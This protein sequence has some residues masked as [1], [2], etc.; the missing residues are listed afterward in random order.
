MDLNYEIV[1]QYL[2]LFKNS[3]SPI[4][5]LDTIFKLK[6]FESFNDIGKETF[7]E[8]YFYLN[9]LRDEGLVECISQNPE[10]QLNLG[11]IPMRNYTDW[12]ISISTP[13]RLTIEGFKTLESIS[14]KTVWNNIKDKLKLIGVKSL[15]QIP[16]LA[17]QLAKEIE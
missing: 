8:V 12:Q 9:L 10:I 16:S 4:L 11:F 7:D 2:N 1:E 15:S 3:D 13:F 5:T 6:G 17:I 14:N